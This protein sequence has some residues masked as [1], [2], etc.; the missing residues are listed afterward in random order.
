M[1]SFSHIS[2]RAYIYSTYVYNKARVVCVGS[3][4]ISLIVGVAIAFT[5]PPSTRLALAA[6]GATRVSSLHAIGSFELPNPFGGDNF[7]LF[8]SD[9]E[10]TDVDGDYVVLRKASGGKVDLWVNKKLKFE[11]ARMAVRGNTLEITGS[12]K[13]GFPLLGALGFQLEDIVTEGVTPRNPMDVE[14]ATSLL[15]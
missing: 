5:A 3:G 14:K 4:M 2:A 6:H 9:V 8:P 10:F 1:S 11:G 15:Q 12:I 7:Q 13:K